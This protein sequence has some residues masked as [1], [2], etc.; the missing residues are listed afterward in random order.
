MNRNFHVPLGSG[1]Y[2]QLQEEARRMGVPATTLA[3]EAIAMKLKEL[4][5]L[6]LHEAIVAYATEN[7]GRT[8]LDPELSEAGLEAIE[9]EKP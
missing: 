3:R 8:D 4:K 9:E 7:A 2:D 5:R 1:L 6:A